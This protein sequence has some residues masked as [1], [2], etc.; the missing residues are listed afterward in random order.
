[1]SIAACVTI[2]S[3]AHRSYPQDLRSS[4]LSLVTKVCSSSP[5]YPNQGH[6]EPQLLE[7]QWLS[8]PAR[9]L[10]DRY[11]I[12]SVRCERAQHHTFQFSNP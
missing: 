1:M 8:D 5:V 4:L 7:Y 9:L 12:D 6:K 3:L 11:R 2:L 10:V